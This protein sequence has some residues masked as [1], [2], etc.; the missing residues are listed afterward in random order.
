MYIQTIEYRNDGVV[1]QAYVA[2]EDSVGQKRPVVLIAH[3]WGGRDAFVEEKARCLAKLGYV[4]LATDVY[5]KGILG[6]N[7]ETNRKLML[8]LVQDRKRLLQ[9]FTAGLEVT[10]QIKIADVTK[11][12]AVG[13]CFGGL[14]VLDLARSGA[15]L[16]GVVVFHGL[17]QA[18]KE[19]PAR[20]IQA[21]VLVMHG[22]EDPMVPPNVVLEFEEEMTIAK[23]EWQLHT[24]GKTMHAFTNPK[25]NDFSM[26]TVYNLQADK[27]S[28]FET[29]R[30][31]EEIFE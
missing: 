22:Y 10:E 21:K 14:C 31:L 19:I 9:R 23:A 28:W 17:L 24:F 1:F 13:Y 4:G 12:A 11:I 18:S 7:P 5:G 6:D 27:H 26:G 20:N 29:L 8:P 30:F 16:K 15:N 25:A 3:A 2:Y